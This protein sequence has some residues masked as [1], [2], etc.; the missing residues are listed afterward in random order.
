MTYPEFA[1]KWLGKRVDTDNFPKGEIYQCVDLVKQY[2]KEVKGVP[3]GAYGD[4]INYWNRTS[5]PILK[6]FTQVSGS[7]VQQGDIVILNGLPGNRSGH[8]GVA[9][10]GINALMVE[11]LEQNRSGSGSGTG[12]DAI[13][14]RWIP[15]VRVAGLLRPK[16]TSTSVYY[17]V[18]K[19]DTVSAIS[20]R[21]GISLNTFKN[22]NPG[23]RDINKISIG[24]KLRV[25]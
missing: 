14:T 7:K 15:R 4:A 5:T 20:S 10:G 19:G 12:K 25:K 16:S 11:I 13:G 23:I 22:L 8:I 1:K 9:T 2:M 21:Y 3:Y 17:T 6:Q 24:Q 18:K